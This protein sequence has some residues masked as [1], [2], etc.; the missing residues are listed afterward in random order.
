MSPRSTV[1][2]AQ[3]DAY[4]QVVNEYD[5]THRVLGR[6][7][8]SPWAVYLADSDGLFHLIGID[9]DAKSEQQAELAAAEA[10]SLYV[11][12]ESDGDTEEKF[13]VMLINDEMIA[14]RGQQPALSYFSPKKDLYS[15]MESTGDLPELLGIDEDHVTVDQARQIVQSPEYQTVRQIMLS[16]RP[17]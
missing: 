15:V 12:T 7:P 10:L 17:A 16:L 13:L 4:G 11:S 5:S 8:D 9:L 3:R 14:E 6:V 2:V 1:R